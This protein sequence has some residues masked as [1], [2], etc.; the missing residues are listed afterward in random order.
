MLLRSLFK[1]SNFLLD[2]PFWT[3]QTSTLP[4]NKIKDLLSVS[5]GDF[6]PK[7]L[8]IYCHD[9]FITIKGIDTSD[10]NNIKRMNKMVPIPRIDN[11]KLLL[12]YRSG[13]ILIQVE[14]RS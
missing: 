2:F 4:N 3:D 14:S 13:H 8:T 7:K 9:T 12:K 5:I 11:D 10:V 6:D 1:I